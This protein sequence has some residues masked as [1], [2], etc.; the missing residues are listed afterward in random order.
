MGWRGEPRPYDSDFSVLAPT[1]DLWG[2][3]VWGTE[4]KNMGSTEDDTMCLRVLCYEGPAEESLPDKRRERKRRQ[5]GEKRAMITGGC[6]RPDSFQNV[7][8]RF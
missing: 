7:A 6:S 1:P 5:R 8:S 2:L 4:G 3:L